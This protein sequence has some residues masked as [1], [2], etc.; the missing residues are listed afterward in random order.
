[1][2]HVKEYVP[3]DI[4]AVVESYRQRGIKVLGSGQYGDDLFFYLDTEK[5]LGIMLELGNNAACPPAVETIP[6]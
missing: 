6:L 4:H 5:E 2:H 3:G 1:M